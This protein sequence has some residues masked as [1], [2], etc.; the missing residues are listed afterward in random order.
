[1]ET[2]DRSITVTFHRPFSRL[3]GSNV[4]GLEEGRRRNTQ[5]SQRISEMG[6]YMWSED[7]ERKRFFRHWALRNRL[8]NMKG[9][10]NFRTCYCGLG[11]GCPSTDYQ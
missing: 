11:I 1:M 2:E 3:C 10:E 8:I 9:Q 5:V 4:C 7:R 6:A